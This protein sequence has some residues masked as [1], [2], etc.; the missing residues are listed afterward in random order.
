MLIRTLVI[1]ILLFSNTL[2][3]TEQPRGISCPLTGAGAEY[4]EPAISPAQGNKLP[5]LDEEANAIC[6]DQIQFQLRQILSALRQ[7]IIPASFFHRIFRL[8]ESIGAFPP[9]S[10][11]TIDECIQLLISKGLLKPV[12]SLFFFSTPVHIPMEPVEIVMTSALTKR[13]LD[14][15]LLSGEKTELLL[16]L[17]ISRAFEIWAQHPG[18]FSIIG[19]DCFKEI[20]RQYIRLLGKRHPSSLSSP[21]PVTGVSIQQLIDRSEEALLAIIIL[22]IKSASESS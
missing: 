22:M 19:N 14:E 17:E 3:A 20:Y 21:R 6:P 11:G 9:F 16:Y 8:I 5:I 15:Y 18:R 1:A 7:V 4:R 2:M 10:Q 12:G 13:V